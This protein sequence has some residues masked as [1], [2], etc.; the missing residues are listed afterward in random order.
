VRCFPLPRIVVEEAVR[1]GADRSPHVLVWSE[2]ADA[3][4]FCYSKR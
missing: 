3:A 2:T 4:D 1:L